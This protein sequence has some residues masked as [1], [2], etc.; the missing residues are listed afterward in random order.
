MNEDSF[1]FLT[2]SCKSVVVKCGGGGGV[3]ECVNHVPAMS[4]PPGS[5]DCDKASS[6]N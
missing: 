5:Y 2:K 1:F 4:P 3:K 6:Q